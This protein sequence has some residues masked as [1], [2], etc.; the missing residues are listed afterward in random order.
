MCNW[1]RRAHREG[2][3]LD[4]EAILGRLRQLNGALDH[5]LGLVEV[6]TIARSINRY[7]EAEWPHT[8]LFRARQASRGRMGG[9]RSGEARRGA[10][11]ERNEAILDM[12]A[13]GSSW[14]VTARRFSVSRSTIARVAR[15]GVTKP[16]RIESV[17]GPEKGLDPGDPRTV[18]TEEF[19]AAEKS[20][21]TYAGPDPEPEART[22]RVRPA[23]TPAHVEND[24]RNKAL[25]ALQAWV[26]ENE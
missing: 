9:Q 17:D 8:P 13:E 10:V 7:R 14:S 12:L 18:S 1:A 20:P 26:K 2:R 19:G 15:G 5:P 25:A 24:L 11:E 4:Y 23:R 22:P 16:S 21:G 6:R 3:D